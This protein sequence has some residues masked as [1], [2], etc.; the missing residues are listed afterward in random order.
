MT[1]RERDRYQWALETAG[2]LRG[3]GF[4]EVDQ[5]AVAEEL[6]QVAGS[7]RRELRNRVRQILEHLLKLRLVTGAAAERNQ[8]AWRKEIDR[9]R[10]ELEELLEE[11]HSLEQLLTADLLEK[12][13]QKAARHFQRDFEIVPS[14][15]C[16]FTWA[17][18][19][20]SKEL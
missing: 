12:L 2:R 14:A 19:Q 3:E 8:A 9:H 10:D 6:E 15:T 16:P 1:T 13:Y 5:I 11:S 20:P 7:D 17:D 18:I 4:S